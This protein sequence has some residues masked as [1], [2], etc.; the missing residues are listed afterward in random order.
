MSVLHIVTRISHQ[1]MLTNASYNASVTGL[2]PSQTEE[3]VSS[4]HSQ[5]LTLQRSGRRSV[6]IPV[7]INDW[8]IAAS[9]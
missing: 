9:N 6:N 7:G 1:P 5:P 8:D 4:F 3:S 2:P